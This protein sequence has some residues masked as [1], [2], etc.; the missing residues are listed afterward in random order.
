MFSNGA[1]VNWTIQR[2]L[3]FLDDYYRV[4]D[5]KQLNE[6]SFSTI[7]SIIKARPGITLLELLNV[8]E[9]IKADDIYH[10]IAQEKIYFDL[11]VAPLVEPEKFLIEIIINL[12]KFY[13]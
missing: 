4:R 13:L 11:S 3:E 5:R 10:L 7:A 8:V 9:S 2:N 12:N 1:I 6:S